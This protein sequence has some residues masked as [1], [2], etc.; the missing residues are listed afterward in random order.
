[1]AVKASRQAE[2][3][4]ATRA[5]LVAA[6]TPLFASRG[7]AGVGTE[8]I[9]RAAGVTRGALYHHFAGKTELFAAVAETTEARLVERIAASAIATASDPLSALRAGA[10]AMLDEAARDE[11][12]RRI[13]LSDAPSVLGWEAWREILQRYGLGLIQATLQAA[14]DAAQIGVVPVAP[15]AHLL[16]GALSEAAHFVARA[17]DPESA[18]AEVQAAVDRLLDGLRTG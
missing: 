14:M 7:F 18:R 8:E 16:S 12:V 9:V 5:A 11:A 1:M 15:L 17:G 13:V 6:A 4:D 2:R 3:S 10:A